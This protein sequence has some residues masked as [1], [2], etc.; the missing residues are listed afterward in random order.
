MITILAIMKQIIGTVCTRSSD[1]FFIV[2]K[3]GNYFLDRQFILRKQV[4]SQK[5]MVSSKL[6][7]MN[8][9]IYING[10]LSFPGLDRSQVSRLGFI[11]LIGFHTS[12]LRTVTGTGTFS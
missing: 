6:Y 1:P 8:N 12:R 2:Y 9:I 5:C 11:T 4:Q 7:I 3:I 10:K